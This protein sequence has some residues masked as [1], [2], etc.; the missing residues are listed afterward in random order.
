MPAPSGLGITISFPWVN[1]HVDM[2]PLGIIYIIYDTRTGTPMS[3]NVR[4]LGGG[5]EGFHTTK[6]LS[7]FLAPLNACKFLI[8]I[9][10]SRSIVRIITEIITRPLIQY[11]IYVKDI[12]VTI[13]F[14]DFRMLHD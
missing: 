2:E 3:G 11:D 9:S 12:C 7:I 14:M 8:S 1:N 10:L 6:T 5:F 13:L 4:L